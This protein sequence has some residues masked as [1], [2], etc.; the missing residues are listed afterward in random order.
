MALF[1]KSR[2]QQQCEEADRL[3]AESRQQLEAYAEA[4]ARHLAETARLQAETLRQLEDAAR[5]LAFQRDNAE[6]EAALIARY[7][8]LATRIET[9]LNKLENRD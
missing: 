4:S 6:R 2:Y 7:E 3:Q 8:Q 5:L 9:L 1:G